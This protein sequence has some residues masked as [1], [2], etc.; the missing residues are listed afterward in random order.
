MEKNQKGINSPY[1][2]DARVHVSAVEQIQDEY[3]GVRNGLP[4]CR[5]CF[6]GSHP[7]GE[8]KHS[9]CKVILKDPT[10][11]RRTGNQCCCE[12]REPE[13][14]HF[15]QKGDGKK[16]ENKISREPIRLNVNDEPLAHYIDVDLTTLLDFMRVMERWPGYTQNDLV[17]IMIECLTRHEEEDYPPV[18]ERV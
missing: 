18:G 7:H 1:Y 8:G 6:Y 12:W 11:G 4:V 9:D 5:S 3:H 16:T 14:M 15:D 2:P 13:T 17:E 10:T